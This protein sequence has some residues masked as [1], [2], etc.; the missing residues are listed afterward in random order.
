MSEQELIEI[1]RLAGRYEV[2][3]DGNGNYVSTP[4][5]TGAVLIVP[6]SH[7]ECIEFFRSAED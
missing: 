1:I 5:A 3:S 2:L 6:E 7:L 4:V